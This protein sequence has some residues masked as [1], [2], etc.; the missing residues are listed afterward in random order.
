MLLPLLAGDENWNLGAIIL[1][2]V[3]ALGFY[4]ALSIVVS[5]CTT[6]EPKTSA[7]AAQPQATYLTAT[8]IQFERKAT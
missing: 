2:A 7:G 8:Q 3:F 4:L 5:G 6:T 1:K